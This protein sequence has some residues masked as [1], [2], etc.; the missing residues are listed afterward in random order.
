MRY[1]NDRLRRVLAA[2]YV[3][4]TL[5][6]PARARFERLLIGNGR[7][8]AE[9][10]FWETH[11]NALALRL[12]PVAPRPLVWLELERRASASTVSQ[13]RA[14]RQQAQRFWQTW[15]ALATAASVVL[16][17][18]LFNRPVPTPQ[19]VEVPAPAAYVAMLQPEKSA[20]KWLV[21]VAPEQGRMKIK[22]LGDSPAD[23]QHDCEL[24]VIAGGKPVSVGVIPRSGETSVPWPKDVPFV[25]NLTVA[26]SLEPAGGSPTGTPTGPV[27]AAS[28]IVR[29]S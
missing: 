6:G 13:L 23:A 14:P 21:S 26:V 18:A 28:P 2:E 8:R 16:A 20:P 15:A 12:K 27:L 1:D 5:R 25:E 3:L 7:L 29:A 24:W 11:F 4:G 19:I 9:L 10:R 17:V 22:V